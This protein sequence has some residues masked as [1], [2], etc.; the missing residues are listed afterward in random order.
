LRNLPPDPVFELDDVNVTQNGEP[1]ATNVV[2]GEPISVKVTYRLT[3]TVLGLRVYVD[4]CDEYGDLIMRSFHDDRAKE[5]PEMPA[6]RCI[7]ER[8]LPDSLCGPGN[9]TL[10]VKAG[11]Y[12]KRHT[13]PEAGIEIPLQVAHTSSYNRAYPGDPIRGKLCLPLKWTVT[14]MN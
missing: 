12:R 10:Y 8:T 1:V 6:G 3:E 13:I 5:V 4:I 2:N 7:A 9:F 11:I 14:R